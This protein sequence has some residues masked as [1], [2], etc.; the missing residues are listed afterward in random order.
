M[1]L[2]DWPIRAYCPGAGL[3]EGTRIK[4]RI[5]SAE[6]DAHQYTVEPVVAGSD[7]Q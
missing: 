4:V 1:V 3:T 6:P 5:V 2:D 7:R